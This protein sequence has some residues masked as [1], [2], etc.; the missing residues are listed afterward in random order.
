MDEKKLN[1]LLLKLQR[2]LHIS[3]IS[4]YILKEDLETTEKYLEDLVSQGLIIESPLASKYYVIKTVSTQ[5]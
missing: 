4:K 3:Y 2:P 5:E 1:S